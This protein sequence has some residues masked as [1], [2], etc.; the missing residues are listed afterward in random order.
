MKAKARSRLSNQR[1]ALKTGVEKRNNT[2]RP[3]LATR[4]VWPVDFQDRPV[5]ST[6]VRLDGIAGYDGWRR[7]QRSG[8]KL[9]L[10]LNG[11]RA[12]PFCAIGRSC[13]PFPSEIHEYFASISFFY[14]LATSTPCNLW[15]LIY[16]RFTSN[17]RLLFTNF[18][19]KLIAV[20]RW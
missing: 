15:N 20:V 11:H 9:S 12:K 17:F 5:R 8:V 6:I 3:V 1:K 4:W 14:I 18:T 19:G 10:W 16:E 2:R 7:G 13:P